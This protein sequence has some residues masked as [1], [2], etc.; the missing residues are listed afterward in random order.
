MLLRGGFESR[1]AKT[2]SSPSHSPIRDYARLS[3]GAGRS[4]GMG[5]RAEGMSLGYGRKTAGQR[6]APSSLGVRDP[7]LVYAGSAGADI[8]EEE[9]GRSEG[10]GRREDRASDGYISPQEER[11][12][13]LR[14]GMMRDW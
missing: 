7:E 6:T 8:G 10:R 9:V 5:T 4:S 12:E 3:L 1:S 2:S 13:Q 14:Q 11:N